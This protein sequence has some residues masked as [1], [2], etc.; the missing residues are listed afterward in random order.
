MQET[1]PAPKIN[2]IEGSCL[3]LI[4]NPLYCSISSNLMFLPNEKGKIKLNLHPN[5]P[6][7]QYGHYK[8]NL[9]IKEYLDFLY[10][11]NDY[12]NID[13]I[14]L[15]LYLRKNLRSLKIPWN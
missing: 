14:N 12:S 8:Y 4:A 5:R 10:K 7:H 6:I 2:E 13:I 3:Y 9:F 1:L 11:S 15:N